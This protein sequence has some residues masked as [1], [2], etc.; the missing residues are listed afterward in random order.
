MTLEEAKELY[1][2]YDC[3]IYTMETAGYGYSDYKKMNIS[4]K[5]EQEWENE[6]FISLFSQLHESGDAVIFY[7]MNAIAEKQKS[8][9][10]LYVLKDALDDIKY[11]NSE[12][13]AWIAEKILGRS[14]LPEKGGLV[15]WAYDLGEKKTAIELLCYSLNLL[16]ISDP[17][18]KIKKRIEKDIELAYAIDTELGLSAF[19]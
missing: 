6:L 14:A 17:S 3:S 19:K 15:Y 8:R 11:E 7:R 12:I 2:K 5:Q 16:D 18:E 4:R 10:Q 1:M 9:E 13:R